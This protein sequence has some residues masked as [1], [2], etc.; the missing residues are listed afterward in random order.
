VVVPGDVSL[1]EKLAAAAVKALEDEAHVTPKP[2]LVDAVNSGSHSDM[3]LP[4]MLQSAKVLEDAFRE[5]A[6]LSY[7]HPVNQELREKIAAVGRQGERAM[8]VATGGVNTHK[9][10]IWAI[11]LLVSA[12]AVVPEQH[13]PCEVMRAAGQIAR[14]EDSFQTN[15]MP[16]NGQAVRTKYQR[17][18]MKLVGAKE[19]AEL[20]FPHIRDIALPTLMR[21]RQAGKSEQTAR[22]EALISLMASIDD[23]CIL[24]R[25]T[26]SDL[27]E[28]KRL[29][30]G[31]LM[32]DGFQ[33]NLG[34]QAYQQL[35]DYCAVRRLS[36]GGSADLLAATLFLVG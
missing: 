6:L 17:F 10:A 19:E 20:G 32:V 27:Q 2:G 5:I 35:S 1:A 34:R 28:I 36:P 25:G 33:T 31:F 29:A 16:T 24:H 13:S 4:L 26:W 23:T 8:F 7:R 18:G 9:G 30:R 14:F 15:E 11:G 21:A 12:R 22:I 3:S